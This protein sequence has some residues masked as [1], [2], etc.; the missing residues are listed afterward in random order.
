M[1]AAV[2]R[3]RRGG[4]T[5]AAV[6]IA[7]MLTVLVS[8]LISGCGQGGTPS[9]G[10]ATSADSTPPATATATGTGGDPA[11]TGSP[12]AI[13]ELPAPTGTGPVSGTIPGVARTAVLTSIRVA[14]HSD[15]DRI[16]LQ[17]DGTAR[18][19]VR[20]VKQVTRD[21]S[22]TP[23]HLDGGAFLEVTL[24]G[25]TLDDAFQGGSRSYTGQER[26]TPALTA[27]REVTVTG[28]FEA[29]LSFGIGVQERTGFR[30]LA[31]A[32]PSRLVIDV[33]HPG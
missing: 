25:A 12:S 24:Q 20:Y 13:P 8:A 23:V 18:Y 26:V 6:P 33:A 7:G 21:P 14:P 11:V 5:A 9:G 30:T 29:V 28:D 15:F 32:G 3:P 17:F 22:G 10:Q 27:V 16:V 31:L 2:P 19:G 4:R 1:A